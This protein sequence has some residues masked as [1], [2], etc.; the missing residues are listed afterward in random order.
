MPEADAVETQKPNEGVVGE[1]E[2]HLAELDVGRGG[3]HAS[4][5]FEESNDSSKRVSDSGMDRA[6]TADSTQTAPQEELPQPA[7]KSAMSLSNGEGV[8]SPGN[9]NKGE[10]DAQTNAQQE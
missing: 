7:R 10:D 4:L 9:E 3:T 2:L 8:V 5:S 6:S 1:G